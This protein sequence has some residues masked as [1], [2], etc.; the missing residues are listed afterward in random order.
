VFFSWLIS[1]AERYVNPAVY[2][3]PVLQRMADQALGL[4]I[5][6]AAAVH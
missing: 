4:G 2:S 6:F 3:T 5:S 1:T